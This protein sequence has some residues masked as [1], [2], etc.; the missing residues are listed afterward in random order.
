MILTIKPRGIVTLVNG[1]VEIY[2]QSQLFGP[3]RQ[4]LENQLEV[5]FTLLGKAREDAIRF[6]AWPDCLPRLRSGGRFYIRCLWEVSCVKEESFRCTENCVTIPRI[7]KLVSTDP[8]PKP[9]PYYSIALTLV[10]R[11]KH[12]T[13]TDK[14]N[15]DMWSI[16][17]FVI[18]HKNH[19]RFINDF[20]FKLY[21]IS[22]NFI[23]LI[24]RCE[25]MVLTILS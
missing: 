2:C 22:Y 5:V 16:L 7:L 18:K 25:F 24:G 13:F 21:I 19:F 10:L 11:L 12:L 23:W 3:F 17:L 14:I 6:S 20:F 1:D 15:I 9:P 4:S 8:P